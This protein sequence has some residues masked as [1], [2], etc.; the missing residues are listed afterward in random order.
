MKIRDKEAKSGIA[1]IRPRLNVGR[2][3]PGWPNYLQ[4]SRD[5]F[6]RIY[7]LGY[8]S[9]KPGPPGSGYVFG[10]CKSSASYR[11]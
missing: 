11:R 9:V 5:Q 3:L 4:D 2:L 10:Q 8:I 1:G 6:I 7:G